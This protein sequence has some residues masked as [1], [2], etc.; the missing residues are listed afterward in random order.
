MAEEKKGAVKFVGDPNT[1]C[2]EA[3]PYR[4]GNSALLNPG[5]VVEGVPE[6]MLKRFLSNAKFVPS[7]DVAEKVKK[8][9]AKEV[10]LRINGAVVNPNLAPAG[11]EARSLDDLNRDE[12]LAEANSRGLNVKGNASKKTIL[13]ALKADND[14]AGEHDPALDTTE[15]EI[16]PPPEDAQGADQEGD[17][18]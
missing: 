8:D 1:S 5:D 6:S 18:A 17:N 14:A 4:E 9:L 15:S 16:A 2:M 13:E 12:L 3:Q 11:G 7:G 10:P